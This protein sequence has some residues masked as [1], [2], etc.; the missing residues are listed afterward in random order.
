MWEDEIMRT[1]TECT[2]TCIGWEVRLM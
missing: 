1:I 2:T